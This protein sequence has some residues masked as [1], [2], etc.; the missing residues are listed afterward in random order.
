MGD[1]EGESSFIIK[2]KVGF[3]QELKHVFLT[4]YH[5]SYRSQADQITLHI[6][7]TRQNVAH[8]KIFTISAST[9]VQKLTA[10]KH[11]KL[12]K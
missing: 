8:D 7:L 6:T 11:F 2:Y 5:K 4:F 10:H 3:V 1:G 9:K 12:F